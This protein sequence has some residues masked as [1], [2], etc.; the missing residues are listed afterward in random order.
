MTR[1]SCA[2]K[3][4]PIKQLFTVH[5]HIHTP[6]D[7]VQQLL[8]NGEQRAASIG[9]SGNC[10]VTNIGGSHRQSSIHLAWRSNGNEE[11][12]MATSRGGPRKKERGRGPQYEFR[13]EMN[14]SRQA[15][16]LGPSQRRRAQYETQGRVILYANGH[17]KGPAKDDA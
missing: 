1:S 13:F 15:M 6:Y 3:P 14:Q 16:D 17:P 8:R 7:S 9:L 10:P 11:N 4:S 5:T 2:T 12:Q